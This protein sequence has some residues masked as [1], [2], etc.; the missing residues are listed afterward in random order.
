MKKKLRFN[1]IK[2]DGCVLRR[3]LCGGDDMFKKRKSSQR[4][5]VFMVATKRDGKRFRLGRPAGEKD[6]CTRRIM[7]DNI[8]KAIFGIQ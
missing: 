2:G 1:T 3:M 7:I 6:R 4:S 5:I 8:K